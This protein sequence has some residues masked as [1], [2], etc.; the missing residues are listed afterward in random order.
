[1]IWQLHGLSM[2][3]PQVMYLAM[4]ILMVHTLYP[5]ERRWYQCIGVWSAVAAA[6]GACEYYL[7]PGLNVVIHGL[8]IL[9]YGLF[10]IAAYFYLFQQVP[11]RQAVFTAIFINN[12]LYIIL[13][14]SRTV[15]AIFGGRINDYQA[16]QLFLTCYLI[17]VSFFMVAFALELRP[18]ILKCLSVYMENISNLVVFS[19][20]N[21]VAIVFFTDAWQPWSLPDVWILFRNFTMMALEVSGYILAFSSLTILGDKLVSESEALVTKEQLVLSGKYYDMLV[22]NV[23]SIREHNHN[24]RHIVNALKGLSESRD[25]DGLSAFIDNMASELPESLP[26]WSK[27]HEID[28]VIADCAN[29]CSQENIDFKCEFLFPKNLGINTLH[30]CIMLGNCLQN[31]VEAVVKTPAGEKRFIHLFCFPIDDKL[32]LRVENSYDGELNRSADGTLMSTKE[33]EK[34]LHGF[35]ISSI[36]SVAERYHGNCT[37]Q[38]ADHVFIVSVLLNTKVE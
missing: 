28:A 4:G 31:A 33:N 26:V 10:S 23:R 34:D 5:T 17:T 24:M 32:I 15:T 29:R 30:I 1:M 35:G 6:M 37:W 21:F 11:R 12:T 7:A 3:I 22:D 19:L 9:V 13:V 20:C 16:S 27:V 25:Y 2:Y 18:V 14:L 36:Q 8:L 38:T